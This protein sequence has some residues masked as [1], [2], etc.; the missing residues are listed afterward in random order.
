MKRKI[1]TLQGVINLYVQGLIPVFCRIISLIPICNV[2][3]ILFRIIFDPSLL[4]RY[5]LKGK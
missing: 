2:N 1:V 4:V 3:N 5:N